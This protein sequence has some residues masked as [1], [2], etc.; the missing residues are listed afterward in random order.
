MFMIRALKRT[1]IRELNEPRP[2]TC[3]WRL[4]PIITSRR[5]CDHAIKKEITDGHAHMRTLSSRSRNKERERE[6]ERE[7]DREIF[8]FQIDNNIYD[9]P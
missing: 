9:S 6:R 2:W 5:Q 8:K 7:K 1:S 3:T 4:I